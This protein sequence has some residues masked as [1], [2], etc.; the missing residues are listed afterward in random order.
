MTNIPPEAEEALSV[1]QRLLG[2][3]RVAVY[4]Y[5]TA[6]A[7][8]QPRSD[9]DLLVIVDK[10]MATETRAQLAAEL[11]KISGR[12]P[13]DSH[14]RR[15]LDVTVFLRAELNSPPFYPMRSEFIYGEWLRHEYEA[16]QIPEPTADPELVLVLAQAR[17]QAQPLF[18]PAAS[19]LLPAIPWTSISQAIADALP[20][21]I[22]SLQG[23][24]RNVLLTLARMW[25]TLVTREFSSK[26]A[27]AL[28]AAARLAGEQAAVLSEVRE[29]YLGL[30]EDNWEDRMKEIRSTAETLHVQV[31]ANL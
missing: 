26:D 30:R 18:G 28:W 3:S 21:L 19:E 23:D 13:K 7:G 2:A 5:G 10:P 27:A 6:V 20:A 4:L 31:V 11:M 15:P 22:D 29:A 14:G 9:V 12:Y 8:L 24:E 25:Q 16:G 17:L 1:A